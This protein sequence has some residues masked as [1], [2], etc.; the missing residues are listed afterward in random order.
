MG[1][2]LSSDFIVYLLSLGVIVGLF[3]S[4]AKSYGP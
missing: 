3:L 2:S 4:I 1:L